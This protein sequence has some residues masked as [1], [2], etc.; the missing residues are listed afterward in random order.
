MELG[1]LGFFVSP[2]KLNSYIVL[3]IQ[4]MWVWVTLFVFHSLGSLCFLPHRFFGF[5]KIF[6]L[7]LQSL[8]DTSRK[9]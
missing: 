5:W 4:I 3:R 6:F 9:L 2:D 7:T 1:F 8:H